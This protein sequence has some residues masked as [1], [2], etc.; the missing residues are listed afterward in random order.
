MFCPYCGSFNRAGAL[1]CKKCGESLKE[2]EIIIDPLGVLGQEEPREEKV[3]SMATSRPSMPSDI[4]QD[5]WHEEE[6]P[7]PSREEPLP[8]GLVPEELHPQERHE[9]EIPP[10]VG[11]TPVAEDLKPEFVNIKSLNNMGRGWSPDQPKNGVESKLEQEAEHPEEK[12]DIKPDME[13]VKVKIEEE[14]G[15]EVDREEYVEIE[16][17]PLREAMEEVPR[18][19]PSAEKEEPTPVPIPVVEKLEA[20][21]IK[22]QEPLREAEKTRIHTEQPQDEPVSVSDSVDKVWEEEKVE[23]VPAAPVVIEEKAEEPVLYDSQPEIP[24]ET[25]DTPVEACDPPKKAP[26]VKYKDSGK[27]IIPEEPEIPETLKFLKNGRYELVKQLGAGGTGRIFLAIDHKMSANIVLKELCP[28]S[29]RASTLKYLEK[30]FKEEAKLL[31]RLNHTGFPRVMDYFTEKGRLLIVMQYIEG[32]DLFCLL[33]EQSDGRFPMDQ[34]IKWFG[35]MLDL[36]IVLHRQDP[37]IIHRDIKPSNIMLDKRGV[38]YL[39]DF[40]FARALDPKGAMTRVGTYGYASPEHYSGNFSPTSDIFSLAATFHHLLTGEGPDKRGDPFSYPP[41][42]KYISGF[43]REFQ[44]IFDKM[45]AMSKSTRY[46]SVDDMKKD[47]DTFR[48]KY[49]L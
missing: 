29:V 39:V 2:E 20:E 6:E 30:R 42:Y 23:E 16:P 45:L 26:R 25:K 8:E 49:N 21:S 38:L 24:R 43:P 32:K 37:P 4:I 44:K 18:M 17:S 12:E 1:F 14:T 46:K 7:I 35:E 28:L 3:S 41:I 48:E 13:S 5:E 11:A 34:C 47:F 19:E 22:T 33:K 15:L 10:T 27:L 40:G 31:F 36:L 9:E